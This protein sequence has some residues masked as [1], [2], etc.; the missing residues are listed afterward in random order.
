MFLLG[1][2]SAFNGHQKTTANHGYPYPST[3][4]CLGGSSL[5]KRHL[6]PFIQTVMKP[7][8]SAKMPP[9]IKDVDPDYP[10]A[11]RESQSKGVATLTAVLDESG[12][13]SNVTLT[14]SSPVFA[15]S[16][17]IAV[18]QWPFEPTSVDSKPIK[19]TI[20]ITIFFD[21]KEESVYGFGG[22]ALSPEEEAE[23]SRLPPIR[24]P[25]RGPGHPKLLNREVVPQYSEK[26]R[27]A[28][29]QGV[30]VLEGETDIWGRMKKIVV[31]KSIPELDDEA[32]QTV[33]QWIFEPL[34]HEGKPR[35]FVSMSTITFSI[36]GSR[37]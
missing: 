24:L 37:R 32:I 9:R 13:V 11:A 19:V 17:I 15:E 4:N 23:L 6:L 27:R 28:G 35:R 22:V 1:A 12:S 34:L 14:R 29:I 36:T 2:A 25:F 31:A 7:V 3:L 30:V 20:D 33:R 16:V 26:A 21:W 8:G 18:R 5:Q 10:Q